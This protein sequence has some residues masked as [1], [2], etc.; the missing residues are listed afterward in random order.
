MT[1]IAPDNEKVREL[2]EE[3]RRAWN[4]YREQIQ[5]LSGEDY[6][7]AETESW[8]ILQSELSQLEDRRR[9]LLV[10]DD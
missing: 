8:T 2:D 9:L 3:T 10:A 5:T 7:L 1:T 6:E 4:A